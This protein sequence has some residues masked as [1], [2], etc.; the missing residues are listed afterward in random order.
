MKTSLKNL[1]KSSPFYVFFFIITSLFI[2]CSSDDDNIKGGGELED[3]GL[4]EAINEI[5]PDTLLQK[6]EG[7]GMPIHRGGT[8]PLL[9]DNDAEQ[10]TFLRSPTI[11]HQSTISSEEP[12]KKFSNLELTLANQN[13]ENRTI[14]LLSEQTDSEGDGIGAYIVGDD[15]YFSVFARVAEERK[16]SGTTAQV[17][18]IFSG[19]RVDGGVKDLYGAIF[20]I[21]N[22]GDE[23]SLKNGE[24]RI[25]YDE[26]GFSEEI[27][28]S[29]QS[30]AI[31]SQHLND[32]G[33]KNKT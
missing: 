8:P 33:Y 32:L 1:I 3:N 26:D 29:K 28:P 11:L 5:L 15:K 16:S 12:G 2:G 19:K 9:T 24:G 17:I 25:L 31:E 23:K 21:D 10:I 18:R 30:K 27:T 7:M 13:E 22:N 6:I 20:M 4:T 14:K